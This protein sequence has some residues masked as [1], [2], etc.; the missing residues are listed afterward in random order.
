MKIAVVIPT[1]KTELNPL[2][3][4]SLDRCRKVLGR[5]PLIFVVPEGKNF[6]Y[7]AP[8]EFV[9]QFPP[10]HFQSV[11]SYSRL[12]LS[13]DFYAAFA[14]FDYILIHQL[15][16]FVFYDAPEN[17]CRLGF[18]YIGA[19][20]P[21]MYRHDRTKI[22]SCVGNGGF[23]LRNVQAHYNLLVNH[24]DL[25]ADWHAKQYPEDNFFSY[26]GKRGDCNF[27]VAPVNVAYKFSAEFNPARVVKKNG[28]KL[29]FGCHAWHNHNPE[30]YAG[31]FRQLGYNLQPLQNLLTFYDGGLR[32]WLIRS[33]TQRLIRRTQRG[34]AIGHYLPTK[35][36]A[37]VRVI[38]H[39]LAMLILARLL[40]ENS[41]IADKIFLYEP[42]EQDIL[43]HDLTPQKLPH[44][45]ITSNDD[46]PLI[47]E[48]ERRGL[49]Y[50]K[51][52][53]SFRREYLRH[54]EELFNRL[55]K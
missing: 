39:P 5:Y 24:P 28:G 47:A 36:F 40:M 2:E 3:E 21:R 9:A 55:G 13:P 32:A 49:V 53:V 31:I 10:Q 52:I 19:P 17:F 14:D 16:A 12:M 4:I 37:S 34:R 22:I 6:S 38:R 30:F 18:D 8:N 23:S 42:D 48:F 43:L 11:A 41:S 45:L 46:A 35:N 50:G 33:A 51:R 15:D 20:W 1:Y 54:C 25:I 27:N 7:V 29:P 26:C 44:L